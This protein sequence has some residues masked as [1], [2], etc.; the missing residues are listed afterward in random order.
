MT[1]D[2]D[3]AL[4]RWI[5]QVQMLKNQENTF[6]MSAKTEGT[7]KAANRSG[8]S[9]YTDRYFHPLYKLVITIQAYSLT[10]DEPFE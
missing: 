2:S 6:M 5:A 4:K 9:S 8:F 10:K 7:E 1:P 3:L